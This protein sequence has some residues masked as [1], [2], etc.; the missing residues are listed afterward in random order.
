MTPFAGCPASWTGILRAGRSPGIPPQRPPVLF[1]QT[2]HSRSTACGHPPPCLKLCF[3]GSCVPASAF[4]SFWHKTWPSLGCPLVDTS[5]PWRAQIHHPGF[6]PGWWLITPNHVAGQNGTYP[7]SEGPG[8]CVLSH[9]W[10]F[11]APPTADCQPFQSMEFSRQEY[12]SRL[13]FHT[14]GDL[15][16]LG[17]E[18]VSWVSFIGRWILQHWCH[19]GSPWQII[20]VKY[21]LNFFKES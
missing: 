18:P 2:L 16:D 20:A 8:I 17:I 6:T 11:G 3:W 13:P 1:P 21:L 19:L 12:W 4:A 15:P 10:L 9:I 5:S 14:P 7:M